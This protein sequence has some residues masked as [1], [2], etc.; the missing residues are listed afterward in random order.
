MAVVARGAGSGWGSAREPSGLAP[1]YGSGARFGRTVSVRRSR[2]RPARRKFET[3]RQP[4]RLAGAGS[5]TSVL[6]RGPLPPGGRDGR[7][8]RHCD[9]SR[10]ACSEIRSV[11]VA[12][13]S[14]PILA[15]AAA[16][17]GAARDRT[18]DAMQGEPRGSRV[19]AVERNYPGES[20]FRPRPPQGRDVCALSPRIR[21]SGLQRRTSADRRRLPKKSGRGG[22]R[23]E[24][25]GV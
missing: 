10:G 15:S 12:R 4:R 20:H 2:K 7:D 25:R 9:A 3:S 23:P 6:R 21:A 19:A 14:R 5:P 22:S 13:E 18:C 8:R 1:Q 11:E 16:E 17:F 24:H